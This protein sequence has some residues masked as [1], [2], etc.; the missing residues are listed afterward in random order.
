VEP[1]SA[2]SS[3][4]PNV[5]VAGSIGL[6]S[7]ATTVA[8]PSDTG[9]AFALG[10][11]LG[12][13][14]LLQQIGSGGM[15]RVFIAEHVRLGRKVA[16]KVLRSE[17]SGNLEAVKRFFAEARAV[18]RINHE[19]IIE[20]SDFVENSDG[21]SFYIMELLRGVEL[22][23]LQDREG[24]LPLP[25]A[26]GIVL[27]VCRGVAAA[28]DAGVI[29]RDLKPDNIFLIERDGRPDFVKLLDFGV[30][31][32]SN[33]AL[34][35]APTYQTS[36]G[37]V[38][39]TPDYMAPEQA[40]GSTVDQRCD[41]YA[42]GVILFELVA[43][44]RP[45]VGRT[46]RE[47]MVQHMVAPPPRPSQ[48]NPAYEVPYALEEL[49]L[50]CLRKDPQYRP[51]TIRDVERTLNEILHACAGHGA[52]RI[53]AATGWTLQA[54]MPEAA[55]VAFGPSPTPTWRG[56]RASRWLAAAGVLLLLVC[57]GVVA[58]SQGSGADLA[59][60]QTSG[61]VRALRRALPVTTVQPGTSPTSAVSATA[62]EETP[63]RQATSYPGAP[64]MTIEPVSPAAPSMTIEPVRLT[65]PEARGGQT[66][67]IVPAP[68]GPSVVGPA[69]APSPPRRKP[70]KLDRNTV[71]N[72]FE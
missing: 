9:R 18:N 39:G 65:R 70:A 24:I 14:R 3:S 52:T 54:P 62:Q 37:I 22:R 53:R 64:S 41:V 10:T 46:A 34:D 63:E 2:Y 72:P 59:V 56:P 23:A 13:Y 42:L 6:D 20:V 51:A 8:A 17:Y 61:L 49:I 1:I 45:F 4:P 71:L 26:L 33:A 35:D 31:K 29:H 28:H 7:A 47:V 43:G 40:L 66:G 5:G 15:G 12:S 27:Q 38:V 48:L 57:G 36:A 44:R 69:R 50:A 68:E 67:R 58:W 16:L 30:A 19:N 32:L 21:P 11:V 25:R 55:E 60:A